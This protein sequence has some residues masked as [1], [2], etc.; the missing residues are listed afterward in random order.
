MFAVFSPWKG[1]GEHYFGAKLLY[2]R[3]E[4]FGR[5]SLL[6]WFDSV[7]IYLG[8]RQHIAEYDVPIIKG[9]GSQDFASPILKSWIICSVVGFF[10]NSMCF[11]E[12]IS[13]ANN[14]LHALFFP[15][16]GVFRFLSL[17]WSYMVP[18]SIWKKKDFRR[19]VTTVRTRSSGL[20][21]PAPR[22]VGQAD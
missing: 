2:P 19:G 6:G 20:R 22:R 7:V 18:L 15:S 4:I 5:D 1:G 14:C 12:C 10:L 16:L 9:F 3:R 17:Q 8:F 21:W 13:G 11:C